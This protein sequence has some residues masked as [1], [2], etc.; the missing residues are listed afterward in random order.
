MG[1]G[2][3]AKRGRLRTAVHVMKYEYWCAVHQIAT[4]PGMQMIRN[5]MIAHNYRIILYWEKIGRLSAPTSISA[6]KSKNSRATHI[7]P[8]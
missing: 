4:F 1:G 6:V 5:S 2:R 7:T 3:T 8:P